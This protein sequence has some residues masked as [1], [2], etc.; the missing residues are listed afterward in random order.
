MPRPFDTTLT[1]IALRALDL[2]SGAT[3]GEV[4]QSYRDLVRVWHPDRFES[5]AALRVRAEQRLVAIN[6]AYCL[7]EQSYAI[8]SPLRAGGLRLRRQPPTAPRPRRAALAPG[9]LTALAIVGSLLV[10]MVPRSLRP[11]SS[12]PETASLVASPR[13]TTD[14]PLATPAWVLPASAPTPSTAPRL[15]SG[16]VRP[17]SII[18]RETDAV[19]ARARR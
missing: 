12:L 1:T 5:D 6:E 3:W 8:P 15:R 2:E 18:S 7:L 11:A 19:I 4:R 10:V 13:I 14:R 9:L 16:P 17:Q